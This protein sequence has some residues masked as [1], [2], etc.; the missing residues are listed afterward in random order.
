MKR[1]GR[2]I[3]CMGAS[4]GKNIVAEDCKGKIKGLVVLDDPAPAVGVAGEKGYLPL[5]WP[6]IVGSVRGDDAPEPDLTADLAE[7][8]LVD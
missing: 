8:S 3:R 4:K 6:A 7:V 2:G 5:D 1:E